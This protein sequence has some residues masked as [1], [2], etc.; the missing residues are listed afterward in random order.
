[1][2]YLFIKRKSKHT[3]LLLHGT[4]G[5]EMSLVNLASSIDQDVN[6]LA[7]RGNVVEYGHNRFFKRDGVGKYDIENLTLE[8]NN[9]NSFLDKVS[10]EE[11]IDRKYITGIGFSNGANIMQ[12]LF[13]L[14]GKR[15]YAGMLLSPSFLQ[16]DVKFADLK[17]LPIY[18][19]QS[20][21]DP[22]SSEVDAKLLEKALNDSNANLT[23]FWFNEGHTVTKAVLDGAINF[24][25][26]IK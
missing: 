15:L 1:M 3:F 4:G 19:A 18:L 23:S 22:Y 21:N 9:L 17:G 20:K 14:K 26:E 24:W 11:G 12:S 7:L 13:Q 2:K 6:I 10:R 16:P 25:N 8:T 5:N